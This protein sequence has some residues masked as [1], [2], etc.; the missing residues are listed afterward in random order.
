MGEGAHL[1]VGTVVSTAQ[2][3][4]G[5]EQDGGPVVPPVCLGE[6]GRLHRHQRQDRQ[7]TGRQRRRVRRPERPL[8]AGQVPRLQAVR[9]PYAAG[10]RPRVVAGEQGGAA[11]PPFGVVEQV[12]RPV[13]DDE[14]AVAYA[15]GHTYAARRLVGCDGGHSAVRGPAGFAFAGT[16]PLFTGYVMLATVT[17]PDEL[18]PGINLTPTGM[19]LRMPAQ[20]YIGMMDFDGGAFDR[21]RRPSLDHLQTVLRH[22]SGTDVTLSDVRLVSHFTDRAMQTTTYRHGRILLAGDAAHIHSPVGGQGLNL[23]LGD[24]MNLGWKLAATVHGHAPDG[25]LDTYTRERHPIGAGV[26]DWTRAQAAVMRPGP[27]GQAI[28]SVMRDLLGTRDGPCVREGV[29]LVDPLR[30]RRRAPADRPQRPGPPAR[31]R[32]APRRTEPPPVPPYQGVPMPITLR[33]RRGLRHPDRP[34]TWLNSAIAGHKV[35]DLEPRWQTDVL[36]ARPDVVSILVGVNDM[37]RHT[38]APE[39]HVIPWRNSRRVTAGCS[40][41][42]PRPVRS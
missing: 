8:R 19:Y 5:A 2:P 25:L 16:E 24:A 31:R 38:L 27:H 9:G 36:D 40:R 42:S 28:Q 7:I 13:Q 33:P 12:A 21:S 1:P 23:G 17:G 35:R 15:D 32:Q 39:G 26:L 4:G 10:Q 30:P 41:P 3:G 29:R 22:V 18:T 6:R 34:V 37:G 14:K 20:G 11:Q